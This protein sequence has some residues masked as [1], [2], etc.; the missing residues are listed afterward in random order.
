MKLSC[1][2]TLGLVLIGTSI[3]VP[4]AAALNAPHPLHRARSTE[5]H[6]VEP[7]RASSHRAEAHAARPAS[8]FAAQPGA[9]TAHHKAKAAD[10]QQPARLTKRGQ[11]RASRT[12]EKIV[13]GKKRFEA[14]SGI[15]CWDLINNVTKRGI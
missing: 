11:A 14:R 5:P 1:V 8:R 6:L 12:L 4:G 15:G 10:D 2:S 3:G 13:F 9:A 7:H